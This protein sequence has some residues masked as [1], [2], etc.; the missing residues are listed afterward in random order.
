[1]IRL[2]CCFRRPLLSAF[3]LR[4]SSAEPSSELPA[5]LLLHH[6]SSSSEVRDHAVQKFCKGDLSVEVLLDTYKSSLDCTTL[7]ALHESI[8]KCGRAN[9]LTRRLQGAALDLFQTRFDCH[10]FATLLKRFSDTGMLTED[11]IREIEPI[12]WHH[13]ESFAPHQWIAALIAMS[14][15]RTWVP[16]GDGLNRVVSLFC[17]PGVEINLSDA[18]ELAWLI[19]ARHKFVSDHLLDACEQLVAV[20]WQMLK[21]IEI[22]QLSKVFFHGKRVEP[23]KFLNKAAL[24]LFHDMSFQ[25]SATFISI[26][27]HTS[28]VDPRL[29]ELVADRGQWHRYSLFRLPKLLSMFCYE[30]RSHT[31]AAQGIVDVIARSIKMYDGET[32]HRVL[33]MC[34]M[35]PYVNTDHLHSAIETHM[36]DKKEFTLRGLDHFMDQ[37]F[38]TIV[39]RNTCQLVCEDLKEALKNPNGS[40]DP[41]HVLRAIFVASDLEYF[42][43][44]FMELALK[45]LADRISSIRRLDLAVSTAVK[46]ICNRP[47]VKQFS[48]CL[49]EECLSET[50]R[51][52]RLLLGH[53]QVPSAG[54]PLASVQSDEVLTARQLIVDSNAVIMRLGISPKLVES[55]AALACKPSVIGAL[56]T[57][58]LLLLTSLLNRTQGLEERVAKAILMAVVEHHLVPDV[59]RNCLVGFIRE[60]SGSALCSSTLK[61]L[62]HRASDMVDGFTVA[63]IVQM[64]PTDPLDWGYLPADF[65]HFVQQRIL[66]NFNQL[67]DSELVSTFTSVSGFGESA[68]LDAL[69]STLCNA[70]F[71]QCSPFSTSLTCSDWLLV[72]MARHISASQAKFGLHRLVLCLQNGEDFPVPHRL[73][74]PHLFPRLLV[75]CLN[76]EY[77]PLFLFTALDE[78]FCEHAPTFQECRH[79]ML[80]VRQ[81][82]V[83]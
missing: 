59:D 27:S 37:N 75:L 69:Y 55:M 49:A 68:R 42:D 65:L 77:I 70:I 39:P 81:F 50:L 38:Q 76:V 61:S 28:C 5:Q 6:G 36:A 20:K 3:S 35:M 71:H 44:E 4:A 40:V 48:R 15:T 30:G 46:G 62:F 60:L 41:D 63:E 83:G 47:T 29:L 10:D 18:C 1:M 24:R 74:V 21:Q 78:Y 43:Q 13:L 34:F 22:V 7:S 53:S 19:T 32:L 2:A 23:F 52:Y 26:A 64:L 80:S 67:R 51:R 31:S 9:E 66:R 33:R 45:Y 54:K 17:R 16:P 72:L 8:V 58:D 14:K 79:I 11:F 25:H 57:S 56:F 12:F 82:A 73:P